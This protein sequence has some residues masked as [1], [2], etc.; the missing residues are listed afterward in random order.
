MHTCP[1]LFSWRI[2]RE[3]EPWRLRS[4]RVRPVRPPRDRE[5][6]ELVRREQDAVHQIGALY[7]L[8]AEHIAQP[9]DEQDARIIGNLQ[10]RIDRL[11]NART[12]LVKTIGVRFPEYAALVNPESPGLETA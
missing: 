1:G 12:V 8:L 2:R 5:S 4:I 10:S 11:R 6:A 9:A 3:A 7:G